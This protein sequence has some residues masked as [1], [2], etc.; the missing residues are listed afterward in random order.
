MARLKIESFT[1]RN[2][3]GEKTTIDYP[4]NSLCTLYFFVVL[5]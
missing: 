3:G 2:K 1:Q 5:V 4:P